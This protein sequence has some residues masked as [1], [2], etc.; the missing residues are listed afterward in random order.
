MQVILIL[1]TTHENVGGSEIPQPYAGF[2]SWFGF[3]TL[4]VIQL[5]PFDC[6]YERSFDH[7]DA[8][9][10]V[11]LV[12]PLL[13]AAAVALT[14]YARAK[15]WKGVGSLSDTFSMWLT[16]MFLVLPVIARRISQSFRCSEYGACGFWIPAIIS[17]LR[18][19]THRYTQCALSHASLRRRG[20]QPPRERRVDGLRHEAIRDDGRFRRSHGSGA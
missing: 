3:L 11:A 19:I 17:C 6:A 20:V 12:P 16:V 9:L 13:L 7:L 15:K 8:L 4:D 14:L 1:D 5:V 10:L 2:L 18:R